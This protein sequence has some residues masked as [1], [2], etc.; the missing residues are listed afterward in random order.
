MYDYKVHLR[1]SV[2]IYTAAHGTLRTAK[3]DSTSS[4]SLEWLI[5]MEGNTFGFK[6]WL[7]TVDKTRFPKAAS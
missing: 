6:T 3:A 5:A 7:R 1:R 4:R 2:N